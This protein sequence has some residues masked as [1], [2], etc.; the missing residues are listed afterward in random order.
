[1]LHWVEANDKIAGL[2]SLESDRNKVGKFLT[3]K[4]SPSSATDVASTVGGSIRWPWS[5]VALLLTY[6]DFPFSEHLDDVS[7]NSGGHPFDGSRVIC[8]SMS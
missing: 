2:M 3:G 6:V 8:S 4:S 5:L 1:M 7:L